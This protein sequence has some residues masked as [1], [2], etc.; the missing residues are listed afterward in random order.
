[1]ARRAWL[2]YSE[3]RKA[4]V[5]EARLCRGRYLCAACGETVN[6]IE[7][8]HQTECGSFATWEEFSKFCQ[9]LFCDRSE[10]EAICKTCHLA[11]TNLYKANNKKT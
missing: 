7:I 4:V 11:K 2:F 5:N 8:N 3:E 10:L 6:K 1:M 9:R